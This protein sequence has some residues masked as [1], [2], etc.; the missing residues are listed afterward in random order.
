MKNEKVFKLQV[1]TLL[2]L[3][4]CKIYPAL[5]RLLIDS[6]PKP[7]KSIMLCIFRFHVIKATFY[8]CCN[9]N[10]LPESNLENKQTLNFEQVFIKQ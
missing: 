4:N 7:S 2:S 8:L 10:N 5:D 9:I 3:L 1:Y 6:Q